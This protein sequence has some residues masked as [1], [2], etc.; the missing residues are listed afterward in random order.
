MLRGDRYAMLIN[1]LLIEFCFPY[2]KV[3]SDAQDHQN[4]LLTH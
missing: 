1:D 3:S 4:D 2:W